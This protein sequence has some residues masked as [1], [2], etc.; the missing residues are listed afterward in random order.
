MSK[1]AH[2]WIE[3]IYDQSWAVNWPKIYAWW[4]ANVIILT[5]GAKPPSKCFWN[6]M[7][8]SVALEG[9][10]K[11]KV[12]APP[13]ADSKW[14]L[15]LSFLCFLEAIRW[16]WCVSALLFQ[17]GFDSVCFRRG[18]ESVAT[19]TNISGEE[20]KYSPAAA[21]S[22]CSSASN[23]SCTYLGMRI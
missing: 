13:H 10:L 7:W 18:I 9:G 4:K 23:A 20:I 11:Q 1:L 8:V 14:L 22:F 5:A 21:R 19:A 15:T 6:D 2:H 17:S 3:I 16:S 12:C